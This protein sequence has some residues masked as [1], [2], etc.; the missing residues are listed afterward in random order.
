MYRDFIILGLQFRKYRE[1]AQA[2]GG[3]APPEARLVP[4]MFGAVLAPL[5]L[6]LFGLTSFQNVPWIIPILS[7]MFFG[8]GMVYAY[9]S[10]FTYLVDAY[11][12]VAAS[13]LASNSFLRS[14]FAAG[15]PLFGNQ[16]YEQLGAVGGSC[17]L[18]GLM[19]LCIPLPFVFYK[20]GGR[21][22]EQSPYGAT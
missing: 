5:G 8:M 11:R 2:N 7:T 14:A 9:T 12:P 3:V 17:L 16:M 6:I 15:F 21:I 18:G 10:T 19:A 13:A 1:T 22:R 4:G 20:I